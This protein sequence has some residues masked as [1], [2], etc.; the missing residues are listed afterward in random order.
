MTY[1]IAIGS[2]NRVKNS[3]TVEGF[4]LCFP[5]KKLEFHSFNSSSGIT[6]MPFKTQELIS[7]AKNR[8]EN[9]LNA[10]K[11]NHKLNQLIGNTFFGVGLEGGITYEESID[12][13]LLCG[14][15]AV[16]HESK[17]IINFAKTASMQLPEVVANMVHNGL[18]LATVM[19]ELS[20]MKNTREDIG[21]FGILTNNLFTRQDSFKE[22]VVLACAPFYHK[23]DS[24]NLYEIN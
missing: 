14:W 17:D 5:E 11:T 22:A 13:W 8:A 21:A 2:K 7:G 20:G 3:A 1:R 18:E 15:V 16:I 24:K 9:A 19:D 10:L 4:K 23:I 6:R 12:K